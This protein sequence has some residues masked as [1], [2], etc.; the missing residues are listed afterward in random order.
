M[1]EPTPKQPFLTVFL[2]AL[3]HGGKPYICFR[4]RKNPQISQRMGQERW[5]R[6]SKQYGCY[7]HVP[8]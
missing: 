5:V 6:F 3:S 8:E 4:Y 7:C 2:N 1:M